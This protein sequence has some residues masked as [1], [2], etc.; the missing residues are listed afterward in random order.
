MSKWAVH[1]I[2]VTNIDKFCFTTY[3][4]QSH[5]GEN[6]EDGGIKYGEV[7]FFFYSANDNPEEDKIPDVYALVS[8]YGP[9]DLSLLSDSFNCLWACTYSRTDN[10]VVI[11]VKSIS[12]VISMQP[13]PDVDGDPNKLFFVVEKLGLDNDRICRLTTNMIDVENSW[14][15]HPLQISCPALFTSF[16]HHPI[17]LLYIS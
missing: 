1:L 12:S 15:S 7:Q 5:N 3:K 2:K 9:P 11:P 17:P 14:Q 8:L 6:F 13:L 10:L 16:L 4:I